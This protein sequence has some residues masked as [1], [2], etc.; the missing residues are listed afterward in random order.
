MCKQIPNR[1]L[2]KN[3][4]WLYYLMNINEGFV[5]ISISIFHVNEQEQKSIKHL[6]A[7][8]NS[9]IAVKE[10]CAPWGIN[11]LSEYHEK[12]K[13]TKQN[14][15]VFHYK[16]SPIKIN[17]IVRDIGS[18]NRS[19]RIRRKETL[20]EFLCTWLYFRYFMFLYFVRARKTLKQYCYNF[21]IFLFIFKSFIELNN[22]SKDLGQESFHYKH[23]FCLENFK[24]LSLKLYY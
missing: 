21:S 13:E 20:N 18:F 23:L 11:E 22:G 7:F 12:R 14:S 19:T 9:I 24:N 1:I 3:A 6:K 8:R 15:A 5:F 10:P 17:A 2:L 16:T 4:R